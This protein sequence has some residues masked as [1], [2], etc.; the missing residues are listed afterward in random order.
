VQGN[1]KG[2]GSFGTLGLEIVLG[3]VLP[4]YV[5]LKLDSHYHT[6][7]TFLAIGFFLGLAHG[8]RALV[9][10]VKQANR[11]AEQEEERERERR[12]QYHENKHA[13]NPRRPQPPPANH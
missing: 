7:Q 12:R 6:G 3:I 9:R 1:W 8:V 4:S 2:L 5:G 10:A 11:E 13:E